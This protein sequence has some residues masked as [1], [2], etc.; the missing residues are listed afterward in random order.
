M[1]AAWLGKGMCAEGKNLDRSMASDEVESCCTG[2]RLG[3]V[4]GKRGHDTPALT[5]TPHVH[6]Q[7]ITPLPLFSP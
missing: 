1:K 5:P 7:V 4:W 6:L 2:E 3:R